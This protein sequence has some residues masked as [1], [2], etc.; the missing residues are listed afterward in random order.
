ML[1]CGRSGQ[2]T[3]CRSDFSSFRYVGH[4]DEIDV[5]GL[6]GKCLCP[7]S[8]LAGPMTVTFKC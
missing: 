8:H 6:G 3:V 1:W 5:L 2:R 7:L 4:R